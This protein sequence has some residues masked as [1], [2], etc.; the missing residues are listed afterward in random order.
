[1]DRAR[2]EHTPCLYS[3]YRGWDGKARFV[4]VGKALDIIMI[5]ALH[6]FNFLKVFLLLILRFHL[7]SGP[8]GWAEI[9]EWYIG[10]KFSDKLGTK[11]GLA[12]DRLRIILSLSI[13]LILHKDNKNFHKNDTLQ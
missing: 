1:M 2:Q 13:D 12:C 7:F 4:C 3:H 9:R 10:T 5:I 8:E 11:L 6:F